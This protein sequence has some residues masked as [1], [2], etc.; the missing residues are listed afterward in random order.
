MTI[1]LANWLEI[2]SAA[3]C[4]VS[5]LYKPSAM[6]RWFIWFL[7]LTV[8]VE[9][10]GKSAGTDIS[11]KYPLYNCWNGIEFGFYFLFLRRLSNDQVAKGILLFS[12]IIFFV[13]F[14]V[15]IIFI[16]G[17]RTYN[18]YTT[19]L[20]GILITAA[21]LLYYYQL[22]AS[23]TTLQMGKEWPLFFIISG[24][25]IFYLGTTLSS[26]LFNFLTLNKYI[27]ATALYKLINHNLNIVMYGLFAIACIIDVFNK[28]TTPLETKHARI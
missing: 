17:I 16:Q 7:L 13:L 25:L 8:T 4:M 2:V 5:Y 10:M 14:I 1:Y 22:A 26:A 3:T 23:P 28:K 11:L 6:N 19:T 27:N 24:L 15:N 21:C 20:G 12:C 9:F 18:N